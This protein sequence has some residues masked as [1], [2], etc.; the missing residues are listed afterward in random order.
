[1]VSV[2]WHTV[3]Q[4]GFNLAVTLPPPALTTTSSNA[5][6]SHSKNVIDAVN[7]NGDYFCD[8]Q[9]HRQSQVN[10][11]HHDSSSLPCLVENSLLFRLRSLLAFNPL[12]EGPSHPLTQPSAIARLTLRLTRW[13]WAA[14]FLLTYLGTK[15][16]SNIA[17]Q[18]IVTNTDSTIKRADGSSD[19]TKK[20]GTERRKASSKLASEI[21]MK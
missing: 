17:R 3:P 21:L 4:G 19:T 20:R 14:S 13:L 18:I 1:M 5:F 16:G 8:T 7:G 12:I 9:R 15:I 2:P 11:N 6:N 10:N